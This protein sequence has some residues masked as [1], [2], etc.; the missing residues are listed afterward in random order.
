[1]PSVRW[2]RDGR[3][4]APGLLRSQYPEWRRVGLRRLAHLVRVHRKYVIDDPFARLA[5]P[6]LVIRGR[7]DV[8]SI[9]DWGR[10]GRSPAGCRDDESLRTPLHGGPVRRCNLHAAAD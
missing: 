2:L 4:E 10:S 6:M 8:L 1:M 3:R 7:D 5:V 9:A